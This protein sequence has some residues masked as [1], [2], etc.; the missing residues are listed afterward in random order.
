MSERADLANSE[1]TRLLNTIYQELIELVDTSIPDQLLAVTVEARR[2][3]IQAGREYHADDHVI[4]PLVERVIAE[5][6]D[7]DLTVVFSQ[8]S[9]WLLR[10]NLTQGWAWTK[11]RVGGQLHAPSVLED[12]LRATLEVRLTVA[13]RVHLRDRADSFMP[14]CEGDQR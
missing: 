2:R 4:K 8:E 7:D 9:R 5:L 1:Q 10:C 6:D 13:L 11:R 14:A 12:D 3:E